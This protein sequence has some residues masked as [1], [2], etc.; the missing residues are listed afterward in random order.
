MEPNERSEASAAQ[1][2][3]FRLRPA[4]LTQ[5]KELA[6]I[7]SSWRRS[8]DYRPCPGGV[9]EYIATQGA[10][11]DQALRTSEVLVACSTERT[12]QIFGWCCFRG[13]SVIHYVFVKPYYRRM[14]I[15]AAMLSA[16]APPRPCGPCVGTGSVAGPVDGPNVSCRLCGGSGKAPVYTS[17]DWENAPHK[18][19]GIR[20]IVAQAR[21]AGVQVIYNPA[22][23]FGG[24]T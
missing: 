17:H 12:Q 8:Y 24:K 23:I 15:A 5:P 20:T 2:E 1:P 9:P 4:D 21:H 16:A 10:V 13:P 22:L 14:G 3:G 7:E 6:F 11:I 18:R 19:D